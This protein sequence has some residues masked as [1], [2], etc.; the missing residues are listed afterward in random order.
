MGNKCFDMVHW[1]DTCSKLIFSGWRIQL[2]SGFC[3]PTLQ[4]SAGGRWKIPRWG[5]FLSGR[6]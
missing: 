4:E 2:R 1:M 5:T 3:N 6:I